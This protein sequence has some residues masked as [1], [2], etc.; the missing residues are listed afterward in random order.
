[1]ILQSKFHLEDYAKTYAI[2]PNVA[3]DSSLLN[4]HKA[5]KDVY[6]WVSYTI[7][8]LKQKPEYQLLVKIHPSEAYVAKSKNTVSDYILHTASPLTSNIQ[9][10]PPDTTISPYA[11]F[12][13]ID[14]GLV[15][16]GTIG[17]EMALQ[18][19]PV[20]V[21]GITHYGR[22][23]FTYDVSTKKEYKEIIFSDLPRL[24]QAAIQKARTY[25]YYY[26]IKGFFPY[27]FLYRKNFLNVGWNIDSIKAFA[28]GKSRSLDRICEYILKGE[29]Y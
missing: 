16:N 4:A 14:M 22:K 19:I 2:F 24:A 1:L 20:I 11:L 27:D 26:F 15:Y 23:G 12:S 9:I 5:F 10:I 21:A 29:I 7:N 25:A 18:G 28:P 6:E 8:L 3:W 17:L 13:C